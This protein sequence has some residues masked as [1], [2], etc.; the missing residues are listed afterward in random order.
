M[1]WR[2]KSDNFEFAPPPCLT[3]KRAVC[4]T[5]AVGVRIKAREWR[6]PT[7]TVDDA[8]REDRALATRHSNSD[9]WVIERR[10]RNCN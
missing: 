10:V 2:I 3:T 6:N 9:V 5:R 7:A 4:T 8:N 1:S